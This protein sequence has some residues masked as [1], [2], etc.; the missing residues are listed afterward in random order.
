V[1]ILHE[2]QIPF[3]ITG[4]LAAKIYGAERPLYDIDI[5]IPNDRFVDL[6]DAV[7]VYIVSGP[8]RYEDEYWKLYTMTLRY[9]GWNIDISGAQ[10]AEAFDRKTGKWI[11]CPTDLSR[12][13]IDEVGGIKI[14]VIDKD[15][16]VAY[17]SIVGRETDL[18]DIK[19]LELGKSSL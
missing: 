5:D 17:K 18:S 9:D 16:L 10:E 8:L 15:D 12:V 1:G 4:G 3:A 6:L 19:E 2:R 13:R 11:A 7:S 14:P